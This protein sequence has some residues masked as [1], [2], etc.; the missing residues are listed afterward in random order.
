MEGGQHFFL[1][2]EGNFLFVFFGFFSAVY[3]WLQSHCILFVCL[4]L[5]PDASR[6][7]LTPPEPFGHFPM[8]HYTSYCFILLVDSS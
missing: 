4:L 7:I 5:L 6:G 2:G 3:L 1:V 8:L